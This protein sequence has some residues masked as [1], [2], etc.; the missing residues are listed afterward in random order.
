M[1]A[2][3]SLFAN[4]SHLTRLDTRSIARRPIKVGIRGGEGR[5]RTEARSLLVYVAHRKA[6]ACQ[7]ESIM[8]L[9]HPEVAQLKLGALRPQVCHCSFSEPRS[10]PKSSAS[11][12]E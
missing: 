12:G 6:E 9:A 4:F 1:L 11:F 10:E 7:K 2:E 5:Q 8:Q 3:F